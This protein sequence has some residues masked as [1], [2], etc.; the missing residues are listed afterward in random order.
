MMDAGAA[1]GITQS[2]GVS[3]DIYLLLIKA[4]LIARRNAQSGKASSASTRL[5]SSILT[6]ATFLNMNRLFWNRRKLITSAQAD[7]LWS[8]RRGFQNYRRRSC[9]HISSNYE[10]C[11]IMLYYIFYPLISHSFSV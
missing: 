3:V 8:K 11:Y 10:E 4:Q 2:D 5:I 6:P 1:D 9:S 7:R